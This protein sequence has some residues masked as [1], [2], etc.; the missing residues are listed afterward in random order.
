MSDYLERLRKEFAESAENFSPEP[1]IDHPD[2]RLMEQDMYLVGFGP[3]LNGILSE[4]SL[5][6]YTF[7]GLEKIGIRKIWTIPVTS[8]E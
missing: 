7:I 3:N 1:P 8:I 5:D 2:I 4:D 6:K